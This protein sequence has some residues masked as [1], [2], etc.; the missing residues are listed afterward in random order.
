MLAPVDLKDEALLNGVDLVLLASEPFAFRPEHAAALREMLPPR[1]AIRLINGKMTSWYGS[2]AI[3]AL[4]YRGG[5][6]TIS[7]R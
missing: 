1:I 5:L 2:R 4:E 6:R 7:L 3:A